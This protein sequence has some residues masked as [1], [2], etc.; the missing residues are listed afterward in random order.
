[1]YIHPF[2]FHVRLEVS[3]VLEVVESVIEFLLWRAVRQAPPMLCLP[4]HLLNFLLAQLLVPLVMIW[5]RCRSLVADHEGD[6]SFLLIFL[7][8]RSL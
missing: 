5:L 4:L 3:A 2:D 6:L 7:G 8:A 1:L